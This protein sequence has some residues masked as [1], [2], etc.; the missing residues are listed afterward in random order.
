LNN[1]PLLIILGAP[2][3]GTSFFSS[4]LRAHR[5]V[6][7]HSELRI[8][9]LA[10]LSGAIAVRGSGADAARVSGAELALGGSFV[11]ALMRRLR[12]PGKRWVGDK[13]P[14]YGEQ[15]PVLERLWPGSRYLH[16]IRDGRDVVASRLHAYA[17]LRGW[18][19]QARDATDVAFEARQWAG[20]IRAARAN[21]AALGGRYLE[22]T[23]PGGPSLPGPRAPSPGPRGPRGAGALAGRLRPRS[24]GGRGAD[25]GA[26]HPVVRLGLD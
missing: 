5:E 7:T 4:V 2:R 12:P 26:P 1:E 19:T 17:E 6:H 3:S 21:A 16:L 20:P 25:P 14:L 8:T 9:E 24:R 15:I 10:A 22:G 11:R 23:A 13:F 18:R